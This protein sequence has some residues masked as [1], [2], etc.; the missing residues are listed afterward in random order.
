MNTFAPHTKK[1][2]ILAGLISLILLFLF[3][4]GMGSVYIPLMEIL[5][6][7]LGGQ[8]TK[9][10]WETI[11]FEYRVPKALTAILAGI[12]LS[13]SGL[14]MQTFF[15]NPLAGPY[16]LGI[17]SG[18]GLGVAILLLGSSAFG[19]SLGGTMTY[20]SWGVWGIIISGSLG[21]ILVLLLMS[22]TAWKIKDSMTLLIIGLMF[23]SASGAIVSVL[24]YFGDAEELKLFTIWSMGSLGGIT[25]NQLAILALITLIG[26]LPVILRV[27]S[28]N[29]MLLGERYAASMGINIKSLRWAMIL[30]TGVLAGSATAFCGPIAFIGIAVPHLARMIFQTGDHRILFPASALIGAGF[31]LFSDG[32]SQLPGAASTLPINVITS[33]FGAPLVIWLILKR[34][35]SKEF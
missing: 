2:K 1:I 5:E 16:V 28:Y 34:N 21:A 31:L 29:A 3:N 19:W 4:L 30:S 9:S 7:L 35:F 20:M 15:R 17:S 18:A 6:A 32:I 23:G 25:H 24:S 11:I 8:L 26:V 14:Q 33:L 10:S 27:K 22:L 13:L 12:S